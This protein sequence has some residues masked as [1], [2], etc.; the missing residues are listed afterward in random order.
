MIHAS[1]M[2][3]A[4]MISKRYDGLVIK[5]SMSREIRRRSV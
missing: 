1:L 5:V 2:F 4:D 3:E